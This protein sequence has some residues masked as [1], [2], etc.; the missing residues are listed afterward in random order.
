MLALCSR[1]FCDA[2]VLKITLA[3]YAKPYKRAQNYREP[4][5]SLNAEQKLERKTQWQVA[6][7][8]IWQ[9]KVAGDK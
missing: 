5:K 9:A 7:F 2:I 6:I 3:S 1:C 4:E 8:Q